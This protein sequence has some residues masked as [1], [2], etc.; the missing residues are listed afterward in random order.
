M[1]HVSVCGGFFFQSASCCPAPPVPDYSLTLAQVVSLSS[2]L[3]FLVCPR[4]S[5]HAKLYA[6]AIK[7]RYLCVWMLDVELFYSDLQLLVDV[8][9]HLLLVDVM[10]QP[11]IIFS[12]C[13][14]YTWMSCL[15]LPASPSACTSAHSTPATPPLRWPLRL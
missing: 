7:M 10:N 9:N 1:W 15:T 4:P 2:A 5:S 12:P 11:S 3:S 8:M 14:C 13:S 6:K